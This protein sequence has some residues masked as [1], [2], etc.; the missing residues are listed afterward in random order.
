MRRSNTSPTAD[1]TTTVLEDVEVATVEEAK[2]AI[3]E[4][5]IVD[6]RAI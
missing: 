2:E 1:T 6:T 4:G 5:D 3:I